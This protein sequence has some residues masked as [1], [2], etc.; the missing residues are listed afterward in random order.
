MNVD[1]FSGALIEVFVSQ[2]HELIEVD[3]VVLK[4]ELRRQTECV[5]SRTLFAPQ[6]LYKALV[7]CRAIRDVGGNRCEFIFC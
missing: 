1:Y 3:M 5:S 4:P 6:F 7:T 2:I